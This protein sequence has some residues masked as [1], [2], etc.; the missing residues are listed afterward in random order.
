M[1]FPDDHSASPVDARIPVLRGLNGFQ[2]VEFTDTLESLIDELPGTGPVGSHLAP[3]FP[4]PAARTVQHVFR[5][6]GDGAN[7]A[8]LMENAFTAGDTFFRPSR[9][10]FEDPY[11]GGIESGIDRF[12]VPFGN[13]LDPGATAKRQD[14]VVPFDRLGGLFYKDVVTLPFNRQLFNLEAEVLQP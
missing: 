1:I 14:D 11:E 7:A 4:R 12:V 5:T 10:F 6:P 3:V 13:R 2:A 8:I 9:P